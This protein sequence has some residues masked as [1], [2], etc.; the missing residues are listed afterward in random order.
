[1]CMHT[2]TDM[3][4]QNASMHRILSE[5]NSKHNEMQNSI[6]N[7]DVMNHSYAYLL[8]SH[9]KNRRRM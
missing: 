7:C 9:T 8:A 2:Y 1:M 3:H 6:D 5:Q 4:I